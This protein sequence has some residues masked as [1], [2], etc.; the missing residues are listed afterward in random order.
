MEKLFYLA[1]LYDKH[2]IWTLAEISIFLQTLCQMNNTFVALPCAHK[3]VTDILSP[4]KPGYKKNV[5]T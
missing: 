4:L 5:V 3:F 1:L 2:K